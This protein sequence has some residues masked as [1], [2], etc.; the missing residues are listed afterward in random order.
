MT[1]GRMDGWIYLFYFIC[2]FIF[3]CCASTV[4]VDPLGWLEDLSQLHGQE[5]IQAQLMQI[6]QDRWGIRSWWIR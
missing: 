2:L 5:L 4:S 3:I 6:V 1:Q